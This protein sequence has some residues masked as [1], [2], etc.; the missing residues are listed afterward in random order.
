MESVRLNLD[1]NGHG[2]FYIAEEEEQLAEMEVSVN[3]S[4]LTAYHTEVLPKAEGRGFAKKLLEAMVHYAR[5]NGLK[6]IPLCPYVYAQFK[7]HPKE[8]SD[9]SINEF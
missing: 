6:V 7:R 8:Y 1:Q 9:V 2:Y 3:G 4:S 5:V